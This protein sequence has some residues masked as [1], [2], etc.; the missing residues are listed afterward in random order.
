MGY[1][2]RLR[3]YLFLG[4]TLKFE[5]NS[6]SSLILALPSVIVNFL[7]FYYQCIPNM[8]LPDNPY[9]ICKNSSAC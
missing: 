3:N 2:N 5:I 1:D 9:K 7:V 6:L 8:D 4:Y